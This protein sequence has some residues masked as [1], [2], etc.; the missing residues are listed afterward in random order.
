MI[1]IGGRELLTRLGY[2]PDKQKM[3]AA[4]LVDKRQIMDSNSTSKLIIQY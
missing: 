1:C 2:N 4:V 3:M